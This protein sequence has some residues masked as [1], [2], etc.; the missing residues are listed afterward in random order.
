MKNLS[1]IFISKTSTY[2][3]ISIEFERN[4]FYYLSGG[5]VTESILYLINSVNISY[6]P[7]QR[8]TLIARTRCVPN[9]SLIPP[10]SRKMSRLYPLWHRWTLRTY[11][12]SR[13]P[14]TQI[15]QFA[16][17][18]FE[19]NTHIVV[20]RRYNNMCTGLAIMKIR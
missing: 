17:F 14:I 6:A 5:E 13:R 18:I 1:H 7:S 20:T 12:N 15:I 19:V 11:S 10:F 3:Q 4:V 2:F 8:G 16:Y 9:N